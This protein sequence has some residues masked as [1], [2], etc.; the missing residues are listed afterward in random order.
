MTNKTI[1]II[2]GI[3]GVIAVAMGALGAHALKPLL[4]PESIN[5]FNTASRYQI[6]HA[7]LLIVLVGIQNHLSSKWFHFAWRAIMVGTILFSG[8]IYLLST[9][10]IT[11]IGLKFILG[12][13]TPIGGIILITGWIS[14]TIGA[15]QKEN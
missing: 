12:P 1:I 3:L 5:S 10:S 2:A 14:I 9:S 4:S 8:S 15:L 11:G 13:I 7:I 6:Y